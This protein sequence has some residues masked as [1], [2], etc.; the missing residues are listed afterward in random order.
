MSVPTLDGERNPSAGDLALGVQ[1]EEALL[2]PVEDDYVNSLAVRGTRGVQMHNNKAA[3]RGFIPAV[4]WVVTVALLV[5][6]V[7]FAW[8]LLVGLSNGD[9]PDSLQSSEGIM[10][11]GL[12]P[13]GQLVS[14]TAAGMTEVRSQVDAPEQSVIE[15]ASPLER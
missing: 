5:C 7:F 12:E 13:V 3:P 2:R 6:H 1:E 4:L 15:A 11:A 14:G 8:R 10:S 9:V